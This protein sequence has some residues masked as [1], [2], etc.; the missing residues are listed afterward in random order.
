[1]RIAAKGR[2]RRILDGWSANL[3]QTALGITQQ[4][5]LVPVF[6][7]FWT[8][9]VL[10]EWLTIYS[11][12]NLV[13]MA[14][15]GL[16]MRAI[17]RFFRFQACVDPDGRTARFF[18]DMLK[19]Y[20]G[21]SAAIVAIILISAYFFRP[22]VT[23]GFTTDHF[24]FAFVSMTLAMI[25]TL[26]T[27]LVSALYRSRGFYGRIVKFQCWSMA[28]AQLGQLIA[29]ICTQSLLAVTL[30][31]ATAQILLIVFVF[32]YDV[33]RLFPFLRTRSGLPS[34]RWAT[35][36]FRRAFPF[37]IVMA[38]ESALAYAPVLF[39][40]VF[41]SDRVAVVQW[42]L[43]RVIAGLARGL[44]FQATLPLVAELGHDYA[45]GRLEQLRNLYAR[46]S[47]LVT[48]MAA[49]IMSGIIAFW[50][51]FFALWTRG[52]I[53]YD[54]ALT[55]TLLIGAS[56]VAPSI[57]ALGF[58]NYTD[59]GRLLAW[60]KGLQLTIFLTLCILLIPQFGS[61]GA[62]VAIVASDLLIQFGVL[63]MIVLRQTLHQ[64]VRHVMFLIFVMITVIA[65]G[66]IV[67]FLISS[68]IGKGGL[69]KFVLECAIWLIVVGVLASPL[70]NAKVRAYLDAAI[71]R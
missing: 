70:A 13:L 30:A 19:L 47:A 49:V 16:Q 41:V 15:C 10:A 18:S 26:P 46:S 67:G 36:Q 9:D 68:L 27:N 1:V 3:V 50:P 60:T 69:V 54:P 20:A 61:L 42:G 35:E 63:T 34:W 40:S 66:W 65:F 39:V 6:L 44:S 29:L 4:V 56:A 43:T 64:S 48:L 5:A 23:L 55:L 31:Y 57:L 28:V 7:H 8:S 17:N 14:D 38:A 21:W 51:D 2:A 32:F 25:A 62:A 24:D 59:R 12:G 58:A 37:A 45:I 22:S 71:P 53:P 52:A 11:I 33:P